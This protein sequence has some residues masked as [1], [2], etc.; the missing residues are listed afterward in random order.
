MV[1]IS[2]SEDI[3]YLHKCG[4]TGTL[5]HFWWKYKVVHVK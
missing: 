2:K 4:E 3:K 1:I 5:T